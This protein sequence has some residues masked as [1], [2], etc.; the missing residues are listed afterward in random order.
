MTHAIVE[1]LEYEG[2]VLGF[3]QVPDG[4]V[5][6]RRRPL[7]CQ[8]QAHRRPVT[9]VRGFEPFDESPLVPAFRVPKGVNVP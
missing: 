5:D 2:S 1:F 9:Y 8:G 6:P 4:Q 7:R 3:D